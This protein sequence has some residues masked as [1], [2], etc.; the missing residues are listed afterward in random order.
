MPL[1]Y[2]QVIIGAGSLPPHLSPA[3][4]ARKEEG[5]AFA[6]NSSEAHPYFTR[7]VMV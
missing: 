3:R 7:R 5:G 4:Q 6:E 1:N 2:F